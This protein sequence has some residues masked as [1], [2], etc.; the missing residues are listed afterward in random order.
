MGATPS[1]ELAREM[2]LHVLAHN[3]KRVACYPARRA[4]DGGHTGLK[5]RIEGVVST[6]PLLRDRLQK[7]QPGK[8]PTCRRL[9]QASVPS[10]MRSALR[11]VFTPSRPKT[12]RRQIS[13]RPGRPFNCWPGMKWVFVHLSAAKGLPAI[14]ALLVG[15]LLDPGGSVSLMG[16]ASPGTPGLNSSDIKTTPT[17]SRNVW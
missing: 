15:L 11:H 16:D 10:T 2:S 3:L 5:G 12:D 14:L 7:I 8:Q 13:Q 4:P 17:G 9:P 1:N 6:S